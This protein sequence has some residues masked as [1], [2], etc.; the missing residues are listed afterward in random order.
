VVTLF[1][2]QRC[3]DARRCRGRNAGTGQPGPISSRSQQTLV[4]NWRCD[5]ACRQLLA[6][7]FSRVHEMHQV[8]FET[9]GDLPDNRAM[10][11]HLGHAA[12]PANSDRTEG[13]TRA[14]FALR[15]RL[16]AALASSNRYARLQE[17]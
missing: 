15:N 1:A 11:F 8:P 17:R 12:K 6:V 14:R 2:Q 4:A 3:A 7:K 5:R 13:S 9:A 16:E 10:N